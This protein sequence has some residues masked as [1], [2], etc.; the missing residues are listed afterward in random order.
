MRSRS[1]QI[2]FRTLL[3]LSCIDLRF[4]SLMENLSTAKQLY[5]EAQ[6]LEDAV[7]LGNM[8]NCIYAFKMCQKP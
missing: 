6:C 8:Q 4:L 3:K 5:N 7:L 1:S 2:S